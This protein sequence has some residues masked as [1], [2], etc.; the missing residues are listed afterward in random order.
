MRQ[1]AFTLIE[2]LVSIGIISIIIAIGSFGYRDFSRRQTVS[3]TAKQIVSDLRLAQQYA[4]SGYK[5]SG[6]TNTLERFEVV[7]LSST[8]YTIQAKCLNQNAVVVKT[9][10]VAPEITLGS[11][12]TL[13]F[14]PVT[15]W[16]P[17]GSD[18]VLSVSGSGTSYIQNVRIKPTG[19]ISYEDN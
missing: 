18:V 7:R 10:N 4:L 17:G 15:G 1:K 11:F 9:A 8:S 3:A 16:T 6:C 14:L 2:L 5:P 13:S 12:N 19:D